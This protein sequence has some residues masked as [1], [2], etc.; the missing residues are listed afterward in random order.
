MEPSVFTKIITGDLPCH[1]VYEDEKTLA[2]MDIQPVQPGHIVVVP[3]KQVNFVWDLEEADYLALMK[4]VQKVGR[5]LREVFPDKKRIGIIVEG[6]GVKD[7][8]HV[9]VFPFDSPA[10]LRHVP[11]TAEPDHQSL[12]ALAEKIRL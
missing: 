6:L 7:H 1:K 3:K 8:A 12:A 2:F 4:A 11:T 5:R 9:N 10:E